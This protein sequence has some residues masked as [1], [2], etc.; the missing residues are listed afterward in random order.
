MP[1]ALQAAGRVRDVYIDFAC[2]LSKT[3]Q[4]FISKH[5]DLHP[6]SKSLR[7]IV[8]WM[9]GSSPD[10]ACH[11]QNNG[12]FKEGAGRKVGENNE[13]LWSLTKV[14]CTYGCPG[15]QTFEDLFVFVPRRLRP[16]HA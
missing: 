7:I 4:R 15:P 14:W 5:S 1:A 2:R 9:H 3:W 10:L 16:S 13:Q 8:N 12:R 11:V 6:A